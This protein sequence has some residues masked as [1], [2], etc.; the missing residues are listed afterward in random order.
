VRN[1]TEFEAK[2]AADP[3]RLTLSKAGNRIT[4]AENFIPYCGTQ[5]SISG[6]KYKITFPDRHV[7]ESEI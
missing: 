2:P 7:F 3:L 5:S 4:T 1:V 6:K